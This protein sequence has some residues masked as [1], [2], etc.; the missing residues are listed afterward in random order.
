MQVTVTIHASWLRRPDALR[1]MIAVLDGL[2]QSAPA[3]R[4]P[5]RMTTRIRRIRT[6]TRNRKPRPRPD[7]RRGDPKPGTGT[8]TPATRTRRGTAGSSWAGPRSRCPT[9]RDPDRLRQEAG[10]ALEDRR[11]V[12][13][14]SGG[15]V[16]VRPPA[17]IYDPLTEPCPPTPRAEAF[18][19]K[20]WETCRRKHLNRWTAGQ[21]RMFERIWWEEVTA[22]A[23]AKEDRS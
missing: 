7:G 8:R 12:P 3:P 10:T 6:T 15:G 16:P 21:R 5:A 11:V 23:R 9:S 1:Q 17:A 18:A 20:A 19:A 14:G 13:A 22:A 2:E 4:S